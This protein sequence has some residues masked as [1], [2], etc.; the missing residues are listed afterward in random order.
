M[1]SRLAAGN[2]TGL[3]L[4]S[5]EVPVGFVQNHY[6]FPAAYTSLLK[7][8]ETCGAFAALLFISILFHLGSYPLPAAVSHEHLAV[9][10]SCLLLL[11]T[12]ILWHAQ[13]NRREE[14]SPNLF[15]GFSAAGDRF[16]APFS[17]LCPLLLAPD[18]LVKKINSRQISR[19]Y[20]I[21]A[22][23]EDLQAASRSCTCFKNVCGDGVMIQEC[24]NSC[25]SQSYVPAMRE[26]C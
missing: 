6:S 9:A 22:D 15:Q 16:L 25:P 21:L 3:I 23:R 1:L 18:S 24:A 12:L 20:V 2:V 7:H 19:R 10:A 5:P 17:G 4:E 26:K 11:G 14:A 13:A 8:G